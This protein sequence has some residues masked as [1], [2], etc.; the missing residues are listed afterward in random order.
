MEDIGHVYTRAVKSNRITFLGSGW[1]TVAYLQ[2]HRM[3][4]EKFLMCNYCPNSFVGKNGA[5]CFGS[6]QFP[7]IRACSCFREAQVHPGYHVYKHG[8]LLSVYLFRLH[9]HTDNSPFLP[10]IH[11]L[12]KINKANTHWGLA[13]ETGTILC[14]GVPNGLETKRS[15]SMELAF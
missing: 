11:G 9:S 4:T 10:P 7:V 3:A 1:F 6:G 8:L 5:R 14:P 2:S 13:R 12:L 15:F